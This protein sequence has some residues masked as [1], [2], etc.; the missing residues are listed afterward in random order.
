VI[1]AF[2]FD[3][4]KVGNRTFH[5]TLARV[6]HCYEG[7]LDNATEIAGGDHLD[8]IEQ[9]RPF[10]GRALN[11]IEERAQESPNLYRP[12]LAVQG[13][14]SPLTSTRRAWRTSST[15]R[16][17]RSSW[18]SDAQPIGRALPPWQCFGGFVKW[19]CAVRVAEARPPQRNPALR[20]D[21][22]ADADDLG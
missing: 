10:I 7:A 19:I 16:A 3:A 17:G 8:R 20:A 14:T 13:M 1:V 5:S 15:S 21:D 18:N 9:L 11:D 6:Q 2:L 12:S 4:G 22:A